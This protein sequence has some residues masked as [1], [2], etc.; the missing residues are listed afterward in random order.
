M[1]N[2]YSDK[3]AVVTGAASGLGLGF[4]GRLLAEGVR[5]L[6]MADFNSELL[7]REARGLNRQYPGRVFPV[8]ADCSKQSDV[9]SLIGQAVS[10]CGELDFLF[11]NAGRPM[12]R[13][14]E[15]IDIEDFEKLVQLNYM[16]VVYGTLAA[17]KIMLR[18][19]H[20]HIVNTASCGGLLPV[21]FQAAYGSTKAA[22]IEFTRCLALEYFDRDVHFSQ[23]SPTN[24]ATNI[25]SAEQ[26]KEM[27][28]QGKSAS[29]IKEA[30]AKIRPPQG[31][32]PLREAVDYVF[33]KLAAKEVDIVFGED[34]RALYRLFCRDQRK[35]NEEFAYETARKRRAFYEAY[36]NG[37]RD[38]VFPG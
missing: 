8:V 22:V 3:V 15:R 20:G 32:M 16:G 34:G 7:E 5:A 10:R 6:W 1:G 11:N 38:A 13:P 28:K 23:I 17:L 27:R 36:Y 21:P 25:F 12:T 9:E 14:S 4:A 18:Q 2:Y 19:G 30:L 26:E 31:S 29:E 24:V 33:E 37:D 35:F